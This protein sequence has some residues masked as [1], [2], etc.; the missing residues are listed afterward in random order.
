MTRGKE[1]RGGKPVQ[2]R[3]PYRELLEILDDYEH[4]MTPLCYRSWS[5]R[6]CTQT[7]TPLGLQP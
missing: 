5:M 1:D 7:G 4:G 6:V 2:R 3:T